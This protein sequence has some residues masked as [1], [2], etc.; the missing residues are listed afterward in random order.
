MDLEPY[1]EEVIKSKHIQLSEALKWNTYASEVL[2]KT[3]VNDAIYNVSVNSR[4]AGEKSVD[5]TDKGTL[6]EVIL[7]AEDAY[8]LLNNRSDISAWYKVFIIL[9]DR[10]YEVPKEYWIHHKTKC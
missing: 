8:K 10:Q 5:L 1:L 7:K 6:E 9:G 3:D 4:W 2:K